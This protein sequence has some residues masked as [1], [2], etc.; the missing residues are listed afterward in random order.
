MVKGIIGLFGR[1]L[2]LGNGSMFGKGY[3]EK[4]VY[5]PSW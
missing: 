4:N 2:S 3:E 5:L 1:L